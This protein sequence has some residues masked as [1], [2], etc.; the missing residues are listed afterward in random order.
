MNLHTSKAR[1]SA[2]S[3]HTGLFKFK[4]EARGTPAVY[5]ADRS[6]EKRHALSRAGKGISTNTDARNVGILG[7]QQLCHQQAYAWLDTQIQE[8]VLPTQVCA[9]MTIACH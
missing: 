1:S 8:T 3:K 9:K 2:T 4:Q 7:Y 6:L 5:I